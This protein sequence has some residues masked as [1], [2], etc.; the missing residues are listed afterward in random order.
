MGFLTKGV[1]KGAPQHGDSRLGVGSDAA[2]IQTQLST[3]EQIFSG[4]KG[5]LHRKSS[6]AST[7]K[8]GVDP[9]LEVNADTASIQTRLSAPEQKSSG[10]KGLLHRKSFI[11]SRFKPGTP[12]YR[13]PGLEM[14]NDAASIQTQPSIPEQK[15]SGFKGLLQRKLSLLRRGPLEPVDSSLDKA[16]GTTSM[17]QLQFSSPPAGQPPYSDPASLT[18]AGL[19]MVSRQNAEH[20]VQLI[21]KPQELAPDEQVPVPSTDSPPQMQELSDARAARSYFD[22]AIPRTIDTASI[23]EVPKRSIGDTLDSEASKQSVRA[24]PPSLSSQIHANLSHQSLSG[25]TVLVVEKLEPSGGHTIRPPI[26]LGAVPAAVGSGWVSEGIP[27]AP[28][29]FSRLSS[30]E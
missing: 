17:E 14:G 18:N 19:A 25:S 11:A 4:F 16:N 2:S 29:R 28:L 13:D 27:Y 23:D 20:E 6:V 12:Q 30:E 15:F 10:F 21:A 24:P 5:L 22:Q 1:T 7:F 9:G 26:A 3:P 8:P